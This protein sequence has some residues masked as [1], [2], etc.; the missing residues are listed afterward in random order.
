[1]A[2]PPQVSADRAETL[3]FVALVKSC[4][5]V[6]AVFCGHVHFAHADVLNP[7]TAVQYVGRAGCDGGCRLV[8]FVPL[9]PDL[10]SSL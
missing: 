6:V 5:S 8:D 9:D 10:R 7:A 1:M 3:A 4:P 2:R